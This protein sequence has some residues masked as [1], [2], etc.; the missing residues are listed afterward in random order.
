MATILNERDIQLQA[1]SPRLLVV[2]TNYINII[3]STN[4]FATTGAGI[5]PTN[6]DIKSFLN[7][8]LTGT[9]TWSVVPSVSF[10]NI[11][12]GIRIAGSSIAVG[13]TITVTAS[14]NFLGN[15]YTTSTVLTH[16]ANSSVITLDQTAANINKSSV[17]VFTPT[18]VV[19]SGKISD[20]SGSPTPYLGRFVVDTTSDGSTYTNIFTSVVNQSSYTY[21]PSALDK[22]VRVRLYKAGGT[23]TLIDEKTTTISESGIAGN[24]G[25]IFYITPSSYVLSKNQNNIFSPSSVIFTAKFKQG[26]NSASNYIGRFKIYEN[27]S[28]VATYTSSID[29][30]STSYT[31]TSGCTSIKCELYQVGGTSTKLDEQGII[32]SAA[33]SNAVSMVLTNEAHVLPATSIGTVTT[34]ANSG[35]QIYVYEGGNS[36]PYDEA[37]YAAGTFNTWKVTVTNTGITVGTKLDGGNYADFGA[38]S[39]VLSAT[40]TAEITFTV[41]GITSIG[42]P[43]SIVKTQKFS[44]SKQGIEGPPGPTDTSGLLVLSA[45]NILTGTVQPVNSGALKVGSISWSATTGALT[46]GTGIA[47]TEWGIIGASGGVPTFSI[48]TTT[49]AAIFRG[50]ITGGSNIDI[51]GT[52]RF[53][54][55]RPSVGVG[56]A[57]IFNET[58]ATTAGLKAYAGV[59]SSGVGVYGDAGT[60]GDRG[61]AGVARSANNTGVQAANT[62]TGVAL[63]VEGR[64]TMTSTILVSNLNA[65]MVDGK[66]GSQLCQ[67]VVPD[68]G[69]CTIS[70]T[71]FNLISTVAGTRFRGNNSNGVILEPTSDVRLKRNFSDETL[72]IDFIMKLKPTRYQL[73]NTDIYYH[74]V[75]AQEIKYALPQEFAD[76]TDSLLQ[77]HPDGM[78]GVDYISLIAPIVK[79][80]QELKVE[81]DNL[82]TKDIEEN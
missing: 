56:Y 22:A 16:A 35:T 15:T 11:T 12:G 8:I 4:T 33:G 38:A 61:V 59:G 26:S 32:T 44:K 13:S 70:G 43:F 5:V 30:S 45:A 69:T 36:V 55:S 20:G 37:G 49:G 17:G 40:E 6:V 10:T 47:W 82:K 50:D 66:H 80:I 21:T 41:L 3:P 24:D 14:L 23:V 54:G 52:A 78:L 2:D 58:T 60:T 31:P 76:G 7:G 9:V 48:Q 27:G 42:V 75:I 74:G 71:G 34:Y 79:A 81:L 62:S 18:S 29:E 51:T 19:F 77:I 28:G 64:M 57:G 67:I 65:D 1:T 53:Q 46:G 73:K 39:G 63:S 68:T 72:G 25:S